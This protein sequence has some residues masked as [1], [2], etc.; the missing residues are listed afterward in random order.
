MSGSTKTPSSGD[1]QAV[2]SAKESGSYADRPYEANLLKSGRRFIS[3]DLDSDLLSKIDTLRGK[4]RRGVMLDE[5]IAQAIAS[6]L[7]RKAHAVTA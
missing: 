4:K 3:V 7:K 1:R 5:L 6:E 2:P